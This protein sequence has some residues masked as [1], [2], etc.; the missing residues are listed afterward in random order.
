MKNKKTN[1][2]DEKGTGITMKFKIQM[3]FYEGLDKQSKRC[4][5]HCGQVEALKANVMKEPRWSYLMG[6]KALMKR[7]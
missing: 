7:T 6:E 1:K 4:E 3:E 5:G 2:P